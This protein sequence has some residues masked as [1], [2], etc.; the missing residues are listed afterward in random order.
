MCGIAGIVNFNTSINIPKSLK[1]MTSIIA[2]RGPDDEGFAFFSENEISTAG[3]KSTPENIWNTN[4]DYKPIEHIDNVSR[5]F[6]IGL[7]HRRLSILDLSPSGHQPMC[8]NNKSIWITYNGEVYN[9]IEL[10]AEL[11]NEGYEFHTSSD[12]EVILNA[13][14]HWGYN[15]VDHFNGMWAFVIYDKEKKLLFG[16]RDRLGVKPFYYYLD[17]NAFTFASEQKALV[18]MDFVKTGINPDA[19]F[20]YFILDRIEYQEESFFK[21]I[22]ELPASTSFTFDLSS[23]KLNKWVYY[24]LPLNNKHEQYDEAKMQENTAKLT[25]I[26]NRA[27]S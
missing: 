11:Q 7:G 22:I 15:C 1:L 3:S 25:Q 14:K 2:H 19:V 27:I 12:T 9:F 18:A 6:D 5:N 4:L 8:I 20:D 16:S 23:K 21:N 26:L 10:K 24:K 17:K 13:Y